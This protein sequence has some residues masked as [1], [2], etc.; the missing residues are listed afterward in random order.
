VSPG[1]LLKRTVKA[2]LVRL[3]TRVETFEIGRWYIDVSIERYGGG[4]A[5]SIFDLYIGRRQ[6]ERP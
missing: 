3:R 6:R 4:F 2:I 1:R 5:W